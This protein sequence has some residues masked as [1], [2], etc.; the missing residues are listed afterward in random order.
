MGI[1]FRLP[2]TV[3]NDVGDSDSYEEI[4]RNLIEATA[5][6]SKQQNPNAVVDF[7]DLVSASFVD[8]GSFG[9]LR[10]LEND[11]SIQ[12]AAYD[13]MTKDI[14]ISA[15]LEMYADDASQYNPN[16]KL[17]W[18]EGDDAELVSYIDELL[19]TLEIPKKLWSIYYNLA[20]YGDVYIRLFKKTGEEYKEDDNYVPDG[21]V[22]LEDAEID[23]LMKEDL[24]LNFDDKYEDY[25]E[26]CD[27]PEC[28]YDLVK[29]GKTVQYA[30]INKEAG[31]SKQ[32]RIELYPPDQFVHIYIENPHIRDREIFEFTTRHEGELVPR[33]HVYKVRRGK[34]MLYD[35]YAVE[36][37]IQLLEDALLLNRLSRSAVTRLFNIEV[38]DMPDT[39]VRNVLRRVK[40]AFESKLS[41]NANQK[42]IDSYVQSAGLDNIVVAPVRNGQ[43]S[44]NYQTIGGDV[45]IRSIL[46]LD[47]FNDKRFGGLKIPKP[48]LGFEE[49]L[50]NNAGETLTR[51]D[52][53][54]GRTIKRLQ[55]CVVQGVTDLVNLYLLHDGKEASV[56]DF[57]IKVVTPTT[58]DDI[59][60]DEQLQTKLS[61][62]DTIMA[63]LDNT[64]TIDKNKLLMDLLTRYVGDSRIFA[65]IN[66]Y[67]IDPPPED[68]NSDEDEW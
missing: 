34:S 35:V 27:N 45:D 6:I 53:R 17:I 50:G 5:K 14:I 33:R 10:N 7:P 58:A 57:T 62:I 1:K 13:A 32:D 15:A 28:V 3:T 54:Y 46:D 41:I 18:C 65:N 2:F 21:K 48:F 22:K 4:T 56:N 19:D 60:R 26:V 23:L 44:I 38:G 25:I 51:M 11:R 12:Y 37:E 43:G 49:S 66:D 64:N 29:N 59:D 8:Y 55:T 39:E 68:E 31:R 42:A 67:I 30:Y 63:S 20:E 16:G 36:K 9:K 47:Y 52:V 24:L 61:L 40:N